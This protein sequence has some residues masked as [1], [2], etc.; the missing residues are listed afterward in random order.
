MKKFEGK[1]LLELGTSVASVELVQYAK[2]N[3]AYVIVTDYLPIEQSKAKQ[4][5][6][7]TAMISTI[8]VDA[9]CEFAK[10]K[11]IEQLLDEIEK[12]MPEGPAYYDI[13]EYT[14]QTGRNQSPVGCFAPTVRHRRRALPYCAGRRQRPT[15]RQSTATPP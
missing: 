11:N 10:Q 7:E 2:E 15:W 6:D 1:K 9:L 3:G 8:D 4:Y 12:H 13:D 5:A 14:D